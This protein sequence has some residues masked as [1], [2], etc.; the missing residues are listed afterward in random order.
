M[1]CYDECQ[2]TTYSISEDRTY[3]EYATPIP[4]TLNAF[5]DV[6]GHGGEILNASVN[7]FGCGDDAV[8]SAC[9]NPE[10]GKFS[11][12]SLTK[13][14]QQNLGNIGKNDMAAIVLVSFIFI[15]IK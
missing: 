1:P 13:M 10:E 2:G 14:I 6:T 3:I 8:C 7:G 4:G 5:M 12:H 9:Y 15:V 11:I